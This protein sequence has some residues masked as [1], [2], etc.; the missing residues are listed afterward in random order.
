M[1]HIR[2]INFSLIFLK[3]F[4][5]EEP[6]TLSKIVDQ[7][8]IYEDVV[9]RPKNCWTQ[10]KICSIYRT[11]QTGKIKGWWRIVERP[12]NCWTSPMIFVDENCCLF[13][14]C[15]YWLT[16]TCSDK[17]GWR[18]SILTTGW[19]LSVLTTGW[20]LSVIGRLANLDTWVKFNVR[21]ISGRASARKFHCQC[22][23]KKL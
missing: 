3:T 11:P 17:T 1:V 20:R 15:F 4:V 8:E 13:V 16:A 23:A 19:R 22:Q 9:K 2:S 7:R 14:K 6:L 21:L 10:W 18:L 12:K 5:V